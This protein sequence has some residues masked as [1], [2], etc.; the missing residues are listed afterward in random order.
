M[1]NITCSSI[2]LPWQQIRFY[3]QAVGARVFS[4]DFTRKH[5]EHI[6]FNSSI[7]GVFYYQALKADVMCGGACY[8]TCDYLEP[9]PFSWFS[10]H[11]E[12]RIHG[13]FRSRRMGGGPVYRRAVMGQGGIFI[14]IARLAARG[15]ETLVM[16][17][18]RGMAGDGVNRVQ[19]CSGGVLGLLI[20][21]FVVFLRRKTGGS[22]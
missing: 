10:G 21:M 11:C 22:R 16:K 8:Q 2:Q 6:R 7:G 20:I 3:W 9:L 17:L 14:C 18:I 4:Q 19:D 13:L 5:Q 1:I 15:R 12:G